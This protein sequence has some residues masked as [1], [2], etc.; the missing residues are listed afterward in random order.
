VDCG[1][2][3]AQ[4]MVNGVPQNP[5]DVRVD[6][7]I[8]VD[9][10]SS[11]QTLLQFF[12][13]KVW[14]KL[15]GRGDVG[16]DDDFLAAGG[17]MS[18]CAQMVST[19]QV[20][21]GQKIPEL[22]RQ[23]AYTIREIEGVILRESAPP[24][25]LITIA[26][27]GRGTPLLF[28][29][30]DYAMGGLYAHKV[31]QTL[32]CDEPVYLVH[33]HPRPAP[34][35]TIQDMARAYIPEILAKHPK[36]SFRFVG[37]CNGG[38]LG[39]EIA[40][41]L[42]KLGREVEFIVL[43]E[44]MSL[45]ARPTSRLIGRIAEFMVAVT[46]KALSQKIARE[47]MDA[48][49]KSMTRRSPPNPYLLAS[50]PYSQALRNYVLPR[51]NARVICIISEGSRNRIGFS[52]TPWKNVTRKVDCWYVAGSHLNDLTVLVG[53]LAPVLNGLLDGTQ[54]DERVPRPKEI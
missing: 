2:S 23:S 40:H 5:P 22:S 9:K 41:Q 19:I 25:E 21:I 17:S 8:R 32:R 51:I 15:L 53:G 20:A 45:N 49:W 6:E 14:Q 10:I 26:K 18:L 37:Y 7:D 33:P 31:V 50:T 43:I 24:T 28:C 34:E 36:G 46:P 29:H 48:V 52:P 42:E 27:N 3:K 12:I 30:G 1:N 39:W 11:P 47:C 38:Q 4:I 13:L 35:L 44:T 54:L 16:I